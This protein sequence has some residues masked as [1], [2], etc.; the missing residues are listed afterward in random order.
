MN[1]TGPLPKHLLGPA[2]VTN[3]SQGKSKHSQYFENTNEIVGQRYQQHSDAQ[4]DFQQPVLSQASSGL[5]VVSSSTPSHAAQQY[6]VQVNG[7][8]S[9]GQQRPGPQA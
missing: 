5:P 1:M 4:P 8:P 3:Q 9:A 6:Q 7:L 2:T